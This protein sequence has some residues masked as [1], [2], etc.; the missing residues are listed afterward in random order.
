MMIKGLS[1]CLLLAIA[2][3]FARGIQAEWPHGAE[4]LIKAGLVEDTDPPSPGDDP[5]SGLSLS[6]G[7]KY[8]DSSEN[9]LDVATRG[10]KGA[11]SRPVLLIV[12]G[13]S[14]TEQGTSTDWA[15]RDRAMC[16]A[17]RNGLVGVTMSYRRAP[18]YQWPSGA[19][20][21]AAAASWIHQNI[22]LFGGDAREIIALGYSVGA[23]HLASFLAHK[24][25]QVA[26]SDVAAAVLL[27]GIY[28]PGAEA[29]DDERSYFGADTSKYGDRSAF[30]GILAVEA[31]IV[32]A[33]SA[34]DPPRLVTQ[35]EQLKARLCGAGHCPRIAE[36]MNRETPA[37]V[38]DLHGS[39]KS[40]A[41]R[42]NQLIG[43]IE[44]RGMP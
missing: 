23:F 36:L 33:W 28:H 43:Q 8:T 9:L 17:A 20:D 21:V 31:P 7:L 3:F 16:L 1:I 30:P 40:L 41:E 11:P 25:L 42:I 22:D 32:L 10:D 2:G 14:F 27:S 15:L 13:E 44:A 24:E 18:A 38:F 4:G 37:A 5:C 39:G 34:A 35:A 19:K 12:A 26:D 29:S 6:R